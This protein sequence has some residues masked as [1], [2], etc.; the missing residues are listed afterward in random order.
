MLESNKNCSAHMEFNY[1]IL[2]HLSTI[3][4]QALTR[5]AQEIPSGTHKA[6]FPVACIA[7]LAF[8]PV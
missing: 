1:F 4:A 6:F 3:K 8:L 5:K 2:P 7:S